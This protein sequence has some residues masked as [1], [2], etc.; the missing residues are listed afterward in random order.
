MREQR[1]ESQN[2]HV[3]RVEI[4]V[5]MHKGSAPSPFLFAVVVNVTE[6]ARVGVLCELLYADDLVMMSETIKGLGNKL[7]KWM[8]AYESE[9]IMER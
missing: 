5:W 9:G 3:R 2:I 4:I 1:Q 7:L 6:L 8:E